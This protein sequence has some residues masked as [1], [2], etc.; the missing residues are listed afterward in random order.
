V[1]VVRRVLNLFSRSQLE[2]EIDAE[3]RSHLEMRIADN[4][5]SG[6]APEEAR[7]ALF[8]TCWWLCR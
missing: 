1:S 2:G 4:L 5:A 8:V 3:L 7:H 6:M